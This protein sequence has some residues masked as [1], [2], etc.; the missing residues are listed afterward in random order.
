MT[1]ELNASAEASKISRL[2]LKRR[3]EE[4][5]A[6]HWE[7][8]IAL[9]RTMVGQSPVERTVR[10]NSVFEGLLRLPAVCARIFCIPFTQ[11]GLR[12]GQ[13]ALR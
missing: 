5:D 10:S 13:H 11:I 9:S 8:M 7:E 3:S 6:A 2:K 1:H 4:R 12:S